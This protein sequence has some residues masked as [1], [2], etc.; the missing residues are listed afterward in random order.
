MEPGR[1][2][3]SVQKIMGDFGFVCP[4]LASQV[5][6][7]AYDKKAADDYMLLFSGASVLP[8]DEVRD[9]LTYILNQA[10]KRK[11]AREKQPVYN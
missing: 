9:C 10:E 7:N 5:I 6:R 4:G 3:V 1:L 2:G 11:Q 8:R